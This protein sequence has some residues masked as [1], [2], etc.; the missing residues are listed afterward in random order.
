MLTVLSILRSLFY[1]YHVLTEGEEEL[2]IDDVFKSCRK[3]TVAL[4]I[5]ATVK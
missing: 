2:E 3:N 1:Q 5:D 4:T